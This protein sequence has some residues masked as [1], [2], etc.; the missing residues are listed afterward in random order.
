[1][2]ASCSPA[3]NADE[4]D[5]ELVCGD[6]H[7]WQTNIFAPQKTDTEILYGVFGGT[8]GYSPSSGSVTGWHK[9]TI[10]WNADRIIWSVDGKTVRTLKPCEC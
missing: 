3:E 7:H 6:P 5:V 9:Y 1:M 4:I 10:D 2:H 8:H